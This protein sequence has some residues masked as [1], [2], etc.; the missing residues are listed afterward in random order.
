[1]TA[2][3]AG[4]NL[5]LIHGTATDRS[6]WGLLPWL[7]RERFHVVGYDRRGC[8]RWAIAEEDPAPAVADHAQDAADVVSGLPTRRAFV[9]GT[10]FGATIALELLRTRPELLRGAILHEPARLAGDDPAAAISPVLAEFRRLSAEGRE[11]EAADRFLARVARR[12]AAGRAREADWRAVHRDLAAASDHRPRYRE[13]RS[14]RVPVLLL[15][16]ERSPEPL[17]A[18]LDALQAVL[19][20]AHRGIVRDAGHVIAGEDAW[21]SFARLVGDFCDAAATRAD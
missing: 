4:E 3:G 14:V 12:P 5:V 16:S 9:C 21:R 18:G 6:G 10:S 20:L 17:T 11:R 19:P 13:L 1:M 7:L 15:A 8:G 2:A